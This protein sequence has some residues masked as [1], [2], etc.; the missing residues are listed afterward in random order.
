MRDVGHASLR[1]TMNLGL[2]WNG[3]SIDLG[4]SDDESVKT[5]AWRFATSAVLSCSKLAMDGAL[6][7]DWTKINRGLEQLD[8]KPPE[9]GQSCGT[10]T[11]EE[12]RKSFIDLL[13]SDKELQALRSRLLASDPNST[14]P[15]DQDTA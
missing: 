11:A 9:K 14:A 15:E 1:W 10:E 12:L 3:S 6:K 5:T 4:L 8:L 2:L 13:K 7:V